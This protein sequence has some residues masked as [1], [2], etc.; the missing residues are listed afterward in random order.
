MT[1]AGQAKA[2]RNGVL[3]QAHV[4]GIERCHSTI[5]GD[6][7]GVPIEVKTCEAVVR[8]GRDREGLRPG[9]FHLSAYQHKH[10]VEQ[11]GDYVFVVVSHGTILAEAR[12]PALEVEARHSVSSR[13]V[14]RI[15][16]L[17][18]INAVVFR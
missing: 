8:N 18:F 1:P 6:L 13:P 4:L 15:P 3:G 5:D 11:G 12:V 10:L 16:Y 7:G 14:T 9:R 2:D 17:S